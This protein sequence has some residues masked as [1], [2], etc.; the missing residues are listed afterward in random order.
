MFIALIDLFVALKLLDV[1]VHIVFSWNILDGR[2]L[3]NIEQNLQ[4][5]VAM[6]LE[7]HENHR[8][9]SQTEPFLQCA[10]CNLFRRVRLKSLQNSSL[11]LE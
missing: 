2:L 1:H 5:R 3:F 9:F 6:C 11:T 10:N 8:V 7:D 4:G